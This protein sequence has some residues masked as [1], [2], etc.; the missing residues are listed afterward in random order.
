MADDM[1]G[2]A[3]ESSGA[4]GPIVRELVVR[5]VGPAAAAVGQIIADYTR[6]YGG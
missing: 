3:K 2:G 6:V 4:A 5:L 1:E